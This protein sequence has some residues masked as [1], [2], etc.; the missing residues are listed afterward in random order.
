MVK[1]HNCTYK[2]GIDL[3]DVI[4]IDPFWRNNTKNL[5]NTLCDFRWYW[6]SVDNNVVKSTLLS[7]Y[8]NVLKYL[9]LQ[10]MTKKF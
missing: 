1:S 8:F 5:A 6:T 2:N 10:F 4:S 7:K 3:Q 9:I